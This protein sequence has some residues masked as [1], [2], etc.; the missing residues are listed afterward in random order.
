MDYH[1]EPMSGGDDGYRRDEEE[2]WVKA[3]ET[4]SHTSYET[5]RTDGGSF[6]EAHKSGGLQEKNSM[7]T[8]SLVMG[9]LSLVCCCCSWVSVVC[10]ALGI[11]FALLSRTDEPMSG[12]AKAGIILSAI[13]IFLAVVFLLLFLALR[14]A[15]IL[16]EVMP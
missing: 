14:L 7:A 13:G 9:I 5:Y 2:G 11:I 6:Y 8:A 16:P 3:G 4:E 12:Q 1:R 10:A 15:F